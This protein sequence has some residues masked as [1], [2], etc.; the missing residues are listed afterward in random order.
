MSCFIT[1]RRLASLYREG[2]PNDKNIHDS[3]VHTIGVQILG[4]YSSITKDGYFYTCSITGA[5][6]EEVLVP[7]GKRGKKKR[8]YRLNEI[9][10]RLAITHLTRY[11]KARESNLLF[12]QAKMGFSS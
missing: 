8:F 12:I 6:F 4:K 2:N 1:T 11:E 7:Y 3:I 5:K 10:F 9:A